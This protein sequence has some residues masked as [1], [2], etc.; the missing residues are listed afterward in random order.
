MTLI[1][2]GG[3]NG[4]RTWNVQKVKG[5]LR[6]MS[7]AG[8]SV[9]VRLKLLSQRI[10]GIIAAASM[11]EALW[12]TCWLRLYHVT[13][14]CRVKLIRELMAVLVIFSRAAFLTRPAADP[15]HV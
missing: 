1:F 10:C 15:A 11:L 3:K 12:A 14:P 13:R 9:T 4:R 2:T 8:Q 7:G 6:V 5:Q